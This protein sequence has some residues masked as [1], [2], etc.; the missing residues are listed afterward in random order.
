MEFG[1]KE[2]IESEIQVSL[3]FSDLICKKRTKLGNFN[4]PR[5]VRK[6]VNLLNVFDVPSS[7]LGTLRATKK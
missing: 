5:S 7:V 4:D 6:S 3:L 2:T 1:I